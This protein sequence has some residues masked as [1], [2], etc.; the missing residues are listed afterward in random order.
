MTVPHGKPS[1]YK[2]GCRCNP[3]KEANTKYE[4]ERRRGKRGK[5]PQMPVL[6]MPYDTLTREEFMRYRYED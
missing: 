4:R 1:R 3:C 5:N 2:N 6:K